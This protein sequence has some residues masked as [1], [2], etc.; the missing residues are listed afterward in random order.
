M[1][2]EWKTTV[3][4]RIMTLLVGLQRFKRQEGE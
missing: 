1:T 4:G 3:D 2:V